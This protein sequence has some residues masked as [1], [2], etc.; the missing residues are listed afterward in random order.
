[1]TCHN[2][3]PATFKPISHAEQ[4][5]INYDF[6]L[7]LKWS[8]NYDSWILVLGNKVAFNSLRT[9]DTHKRTVN[10][11]QLQRKGGRKIMKKNMVAFYVK[12]LLTNLNW[13]ELQLN[14]ATP[15][16]IAFWL[17]LV[18]SKTQ[19]KELAIWNFLCFLYMIIEIATPPAL[20]PRMRGLHSN[21]VKSDWELA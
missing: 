15:E 17:F 12:Y 7:L 3:L 11:S 5:V 18:L 8:Y 1:M 9:N 2:L 10:Y 13:A 16:P 4:S 6:F 14:W 19:T 21:P 20:V